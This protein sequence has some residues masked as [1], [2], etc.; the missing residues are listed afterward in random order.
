MPVLL[1]LPVA[2][3]VLALLLMLVTSGGLLIRHQR[4]RRQVKQRLVLVTAAK[5]KPSASR[6][7]QWEQQ[8]GWLSVV[9]RR[10]QL[11]TDALFG[12]QGQ[13]LGL[14]G[15]SALAVLSWQAGAIFPLGWR[16]L[17]VTLVVGT[18][19]LSAYWLMQYR[20]HKAFEVAFPQVL[21]QV[22]RAVAAGVSVPQAI[23]QVAAYQQGVLGR[24]FALIRDQLEIG[25]SLK[26]AL[27]EASY[28]LPYSGFHF[29]TVALLLN[30]ENGGQLRAVLHSLSRT[31]HANAALK[32]KIKSLTAEPRMTAVILACLPLLLIGVMFFK[33]PAS[34][35]NLTGTEMGQWV[36]GYVSGSMLLGLLVIQRLTKV[37]L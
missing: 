19:A 36:L 31:L 25:I 3:I 23:A 27:H 9:W 30:E 4:L 32:M 26:Q 14:L 1:G 6:L 13:R 29:F 33:N 18:A 35:V 16:V 5:A 11:R 12:Q 2:L 8:G 10:L 17:L 20:Q 24:E 28:R 15:L 37:R 7:F 22:S 34:F 21:G